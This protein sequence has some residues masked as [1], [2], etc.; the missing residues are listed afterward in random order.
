MLE[1]TKPGIHGERDSGTGIT[2]GFEDSTNKTG[3]QTLPLGASQAQANP[4]DIPGGNQPLDDK[5]LTPLPSTTA[6]RGP[7]HRDGTHPGKDITPA[8]ADIGSKH[9]KH[10]KPIVAAAEHDK[11]KHDTHHD[12]HHHKDEKPLAAAAQR[13]PEHTAPTTTETNT[14][15]PTDLAGTGTGHD[16]NNRDRGIVAGGVTGGGGA[17]AGAGIAHDRHEQQAL[18]D[19][20]STSTTTQ[21]ETEKGEKGGLLAKLG[22]GSHSKDKDHDKHHDKHE[23]TIPADK[24]SSERIEPY[25]RDTLPTGTTTTHE[26]T[27]SKH[28]DTKHEKGGFLAGVLP[29]RSKDKDPNTDTEPHRETPAH[30]GT[31]ATPASTDPSRGA[32]THTGPLGEPDTAAHRGLNTQPD[33]GTATDSAL[34]GVAAAGLSDHHKTGQST[35]PSR[36]L[37][38][39]SDNVIGSSTHND[40]HGVTDS[41]STTGQS[42]LT[43]ANPLGSSS[44]RDQTTTSQSPLS[45]DQSYASGAGTGTGTT[46]DLPKSSQD[47]PDLGDISALRASDVTGRNTHG[48]LSDKGADHGNQTGLNIPPKVPEK[49]TTTGPAVPSKDS[50]TGPAVP[51]KD[52]APTTSAGNTVGDNSQESDLLRKLNPEGT[53][54]FFLLPASLLAY[55]FSLPPDHHAPSTNSC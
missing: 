38:G 35:Q 19:E 36:G 23:Q 42:G 37:D 17:L 5:P 20:P 54:P 10:E 51:E 3:P 21:H 28:D 12:K 44:Q 53:S 47:K 25:S 8:A 30:G 15:D 11:H 34:P 48:G 6:E 33:R 31:T 22:L 45:G 52:Y 27:A 9:E 1:S 40:R 43:G 2:P 50:S 13:H 16:A 7:E 29:S 39:S 55:P 41:P 18:R 32:P 14:T 49:D 4:A 24:P 46:S 26:P